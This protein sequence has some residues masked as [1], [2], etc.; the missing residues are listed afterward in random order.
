MYKICQNFTHKSDTVVLRYLH[1]SA[2]FVNIAFSDDDNILTKQFLRIFLW[3]T[4]FVGLLFIPTLLGPALC[5][6]V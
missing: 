2:M 5:V 6:L 1:V 4:G 3:T